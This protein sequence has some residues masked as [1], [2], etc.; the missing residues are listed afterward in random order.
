MSDPDGVVRHIQHAEEWLRWARSDHRR[1]DLRAVV[2]RLLLAEAEIRHARE[3]G[4]HLVASPHPRHRPRR[5]L[6]AL[7]A[8]VAF[9]LA[10]A[11]YTALRPEDRHRPAPVGPSAHGWATEPPAP[12]GAV[13]LQAGRLLRLGPAFADGQQG[14]PG[15]PPAISDFRLLPI[16][17]DRAAGAPPAT[18]DHWF[19]DGPVSLTTSGDPGSASTAF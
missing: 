9:V 15:G 12:A 13:R 18:T 2:L 4:I 10:T 17:G 16:R 8:A 5:R 3:V 6:A 14:L 19:T 7:G 11:T 1:G